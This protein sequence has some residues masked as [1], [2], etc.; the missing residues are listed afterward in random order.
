MTNYLFLYMHLLCILIEIYFCKL[1]LGKVKIIRASTHIFDLHR[2]ENALLD[3]IIKC[4]RSVYS[5]NLIY[6]L[7]LP[8]LLES[9]C[10]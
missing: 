9:K 7:N 3:L 4:L 1:A 6:K 5:L 2:P 10:N 8:D